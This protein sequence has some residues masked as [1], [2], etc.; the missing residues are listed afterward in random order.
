MTIN[1]LEY[2]KAYELFPHPQLP[3]DIDLR[4][5]YLGKK[6]NGRLSF[7]GRNRKNREPFN[8]FIDEESL[9]LID[10]GGE[11][12]TFLNFRGQE[13]LNFREQEDQILLSYPS[14][15]RKSGLEKTLKRAGL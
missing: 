14:E 4:V 13:G 5:I 2:N 10:W 12:W 7:V 1:K 6:E 9:S 3:N 11:E 15:N 8:L